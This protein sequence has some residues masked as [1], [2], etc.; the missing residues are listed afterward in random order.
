[1]KSLFRQNT[2]TK[3]LLNSPEFCLLGAEVVGTIDSES[4]PHMRLFCVEKLEGSS[5]LWESQVDF[6]TLCDHVLLLSLILFFFS[7]FTA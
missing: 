2:W 1:M 7:F 3:Q 6:S 5:N 4:D